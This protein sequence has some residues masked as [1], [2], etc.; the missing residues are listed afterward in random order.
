ME[1]RAT[2]SKP[3]IVSKGRQVGIRKDRRNLG[4]EEILKKHG[5]HFPWIKRSL[6]AT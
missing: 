3:C 6:W 5:W 2:V 4:R 1:G